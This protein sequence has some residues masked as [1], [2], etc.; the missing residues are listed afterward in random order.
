M[1]LNDELRS[2]QDSLLLRFPSCTV[3][4]AICSRLVSVLAGFVPD[5]RLDLGT[6]AK[7]AMINY[8]VPATVVAGHL[9]T[10]PG[11][12]SSNTIAA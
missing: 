12:F 8:T 5:E 9:W 7:G 11:Y 1:R 6:H 3:A 10:L 4:P 2:S